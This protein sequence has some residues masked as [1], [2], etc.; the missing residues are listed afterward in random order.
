MKVWELKMGTC[1][2][3]FVI[4][5]DEADKGRDFVEEVEVRPSRR[6]SHPSTEVNGFSG[7][8]E[9]SV[10]V[11]VPTLQAPRAPRLV[12]ASRQ[13]QRLTVRV[14]GARPD[15]Q[16]LGEVIFYQ[17]ELA[18]FAQRSLKGSPPQLPDI[19]E[20]DDAG[21]F[22]QIFESTVNVKMLRSGGS[23]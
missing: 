23:S 6:S 18:S 11:E 9:L 13:S 4:T 3:Q 12:L 15:G 21:A 5:I 22:V 20:V 1:Q 16:Q 7:E 2:F 8:A 19:S 10:V 14:Q 17:V